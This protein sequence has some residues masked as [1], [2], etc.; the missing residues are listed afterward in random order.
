MGGASEAG[1]KGGHERRD[2]KEQIFF[3]TGLPHV[4]HH[5]VHIPPALPVTAHE[6]HNNACEHTHDH[7]AEQE[8][9]DND[10]DGGRV[11]R[12]RREVSRKRDQHLQPVS[13]TR[14]QEGRR[15]CGV[16]M[17]TPMRNVCAVKAG[18]FVARASSSVSSAEHF[19]RTSSSGQRGTCTAHQHPAR[20]A[21]DGHTRSPSGEM[22]SW[23]IAYLRTRQR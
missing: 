12:G 18:R 10:A 14:S 15:T 20:G 23:P 1:R 8:A 3:R 11:A 6:L 22:S 7:E 17:K 16:T 5:P 13:N 2:A 21:W 9:A 4:E 19:T